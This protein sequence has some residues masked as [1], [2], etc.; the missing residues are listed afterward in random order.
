MNKKIVLLAIIMVVCISLFV[1][2]YDTNEKYGM[3][4]EKWYG[5][6]QSLEFKGLEYILKDVEILDKA[7]YEE[8]FGH[9]AE[10]FD[11]N[12]NKWDKK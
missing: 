5:V 2:I 3:P 6:G 1:K 12:V 7:L 11:E 10:F 4:E 8:K 9:S